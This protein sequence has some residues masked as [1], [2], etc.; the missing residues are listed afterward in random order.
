M[1][2]ICRALILLATV[3]VVF[4]HFPPVFECA[5]QYKECISGEISPIL[6]NFNCAWEHNTCTEGR[7]YM[8]TQC[9]CDCPGSMLCCDPSILEEWDYPIWRG[10]APICTANCGNC[11]NE[12]YTCWYMSS[13]GSGAQCWV[14]YKFLCGIRRSKNFWPFLD[15]TVSS[16]LQ[17]MLHTRIFQ[18]RYNII[19]N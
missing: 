12:P 4:S 17:W 7:I 3:S 6:T 11:G 5:R 15:K 1:A 9:N 18:S 16:L 8:R 10:T 19:I 2:M 13:C 14:G